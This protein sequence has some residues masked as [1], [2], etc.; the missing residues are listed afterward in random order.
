M[1]FT[2][3]RAR[4][5]ISE[6]SAQLSY[7]TSTGVLTYAQG[8]SDTV[9]EGSTNLFFTDA[10]VATKVDSYVN[11]A[12]VDALNVVAA[13]T[14]G[15]SATAT[16]LATQRAF[17]ISGDATASATNFNGTGDVVLNLT[18]DD[19]AV[20]LGTKTTGNYVATI[21]GTTNEI[22]VSGSG[23]E[24]AAVTI[25]LPNDVSVANNLTVA[26]NLTV[27]GDSLT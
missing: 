11:K 10:R 7:N 22:E 15:N 8:N 18:I 9:A 5:S 1:Y 17:S 26:G 21:A 3:A 2:E 20:A 13:S 4:A 25:G 24:T 12:F 16:A 14:S 6:N 19:N 23:S 27:N